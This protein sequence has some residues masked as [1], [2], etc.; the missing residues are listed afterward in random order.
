MNISE[1]NQEINKIRSNPEYQR[2]R[3]GTRGIETDKIYQYYETQ[4]KALEQKK[5]TLM[6]SI[7]KINKLQIPCVIEAKKQ[8]DNELNLSEYEIKQ[9][10]LNDQKLLEVLYENINFQNIDHESNDFKKEIG[11]YEFDQEEEERK[12]KQINQIIEDK[13]LYGPGAIR[14]SG[15]E[16]R[17]NKSNQEESKQIEDQKHDEPPIFST[18]SNESYQYPIYFSEIEMYKDESESESEP[19]LKKP[20]PIK[21]V[22][23]LQIPS[24]NQKDDEYELKKQIELFTLS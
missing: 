4:I 13:E 19:E 18:E 24:I 10:I 17:K 2:L 8:P 20:E 15:I 23:K 11:I 1:I 12:R 6:P 5:Q 3:L 7:R 9:K 14:F 16:I 22:N 21:K